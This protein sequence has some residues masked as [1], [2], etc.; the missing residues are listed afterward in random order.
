MNWTNYDKILF[1][2]KLELYQLFAQNKQN[3]KYKIILFYLN[4]FKFNNK[5][6]FKLSI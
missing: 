1:S 5:Y 6:I 4:R 2:K 3:V